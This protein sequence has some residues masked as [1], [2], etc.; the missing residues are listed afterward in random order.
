MKLIDVINEIANLPNEDKVNIRGKFYTTVDT[1]LQCFR[2]VFGS[3]ARVTTDIIINDL[4]RVVVKATVSIYQDGK[5]RDI[6][7]D[8]AEEF[9]NQ[10]PVN[11]TSALENC[12]TSAIGRALANCGLGGGEYASAFEVDNAINSKETAP[13]LSKGYVFI[14]VDGHKIGH[15]ADE[16]AFL[17]KCRKYLSDPADPD[18]H[19]LFRKNSDEIEKAYDN[20]KEGS[21]ERTAYEKLVEIYVKK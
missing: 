6:G 17:D 16:S 19:A 21:K 1:R 9:R 7:N 14:N 8:F 18:H 12:T 2:K 20:T 13:D 5:W 4:E 11:K 10:G 3:D 15:S